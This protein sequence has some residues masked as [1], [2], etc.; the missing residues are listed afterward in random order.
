MRRT[1]LALAL[2]G[3]TMPAAA[4]MTPVAPRAGA[5]LSADADGDGAVTRAEASAAADT[6]FDR[7]DADHDGTITRKEMGLARD[8]LR[9]RRGRDGTPVTPVPADGARPNSPARLILG[10]TR[11]ESRARALRA[12]D[13]ADA[14]Q[15][16]RVDGAELA[17][18]RSMRRAPRGDGAGGYMPLLAKD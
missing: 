14:N 11:D 15:D 8:L 9:G 18:L 4:Q 6:R 1:I 2:A 3:S 16:G 12:F 5:L 7:L 13:R 17:Q 10:I